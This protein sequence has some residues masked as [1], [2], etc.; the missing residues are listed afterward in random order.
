MSEI[1]DRILAVKE[2]VERAAVKAGRDP[3]EITVIAV[4]KTVGKEEILD[5][6]ENAEQL[7]FGENRVQAL[8]EKYDPR[9][10]WHLIGHLQK[11]KVKYIID[12]VDLI[13][14]VDSIAL[15]EELEKQAQKVSRVIPF[16]LQVNVSG[17]ATK[18]G[19]APE[20]IF[21]IVTKMSQYGN[22]KLKGFMT[23]A[24]YVTDPEETRVF[25][26]QLK[27]I[28]IDIRNRKLHNVDMECLSM[29][30][31]NDFEV[32]VEEG[33]N[34]IRVGTSIFTKGKKI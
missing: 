16:L 34:L 24:P 3:S 13:H 27:D 11:N 5:A 9:M 31:S 17:E 12:K 8:L 4:S 2:R 26:R 1:A 21:G 29:G 28:Y 25:F 15:M 10:K 18:F 19:V 6:Y 14:S 33:A 22:I 20:E 30:M 23:M 32:A 7:Y